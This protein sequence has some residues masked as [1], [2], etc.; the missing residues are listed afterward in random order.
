MNKRSRFVSA[1]APLVVLLL[2]AAVGATPTRGLEGALHL[3]LLRSSPAADTTVAEAPDTLRLWF[4]ETPQLSATSVRLVGPEGDLVE[5]GDPAFG[6]DEETLV[7]VVVAGEV[8][9]GTNRVLW[10]TMAR[11][12]HVLTGEISFTVE[13]PGGVAR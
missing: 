8:S 5:T 6:D 9:P 11:D 1:A 4:S 10:R 3:S 7:E 12:G 13:G 2:T